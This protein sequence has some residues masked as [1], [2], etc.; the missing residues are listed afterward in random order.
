MHFLLPLFSSFFLFVSPKPQRFLSRIRE[1]FCIRNICNGYNLMN[2]VHSKWNVKDFETNRFLLE[3]FWYCVCKWIGL[4]S[5]ASC[6]WMVLMVR[7][8]WHISRHSATKHNSI[9]YCWLWRFTL[10][11]AWQF[12]WN[13]IVAVFSEQIHGY[14]LS[15]S[16]KFNHIASHQ[17]NRCWE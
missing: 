15:S 3:A 16:L 12:K 2:R 6:V 17:L 8:A 5:S 13:R 4:F 11:V 9:E 1:F 10:Y 14:W 7:L